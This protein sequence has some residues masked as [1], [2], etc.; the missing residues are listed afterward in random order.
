MVLLTL[1][2]WRRRVLQ[3]STS[4][5][6]LGGLRARLTG[7]VRNRFP[8]E[9]ALVSDTDL[10]AAADGVLWRPEEDGRLQPTDLVDW[11]RS[12]FGAAGITLSFADREPTVSVDDLESWEALLDHVDADALVTAFL[13]FQR[14]SSDPDADIRDLTHWGV[15]VRAGDRSLA[16]L[17]RQGVSDLHVHA[18]GV[19]FAHLA[20]FDLMDAQ[21]EAKTFSGLREKEQT[22]VALG[23]RCRSDLWN[24]LGVR[25]RPSE[26]APLS[27]LEEQWWRWD[28]RRLL[29]ERIL[30]AR[31]WQSA[32]KAPAVMRALD[33]YLFAK[34]CFFSEARQPGHTAPGLRVF[35]RYF[36]YVARTPGFVG[37]EV[38]AR[39]AMLPFG[40]ALAYLADCPN[41]ER[42]ELRAAPAGTAS[43]YGGL[44]KAF[45]Q[46]VQRFNSARGTNTDVRLAIHFKRS[47]R[48]S[49]RSGGLS[50]LSKTLR[51]LDR[52]S[53]ALRTA[54]AD[55]AFG[56]H[57]RYWLS[58]LDV[59][60]WERDT[61]AAYFAPYLR[62]ARGD[63][64]ALQD[65]EELDPED[66]R[67]PEFEAWLALRDRHDHR[68]SLAEARL[69]LTVHAG[70]DFADPLDGLCQ[71]ATAMQAFDMKPGDG[72]GHGLAIAVDLTR[73]D[74]ER[75]GFARIRQ[76]AHL[77]SLLWLCTLRTKTRSLDDFPAVADRVRR[78]VEQIAHTVYGLRCSI[79]D[80]LWLRQ[81]RIRPKSPNGLSRVR[82]QL[83]RLDVRTDVRSR[84]DILLPL[85]PVRS[86]LQD[87]VAWAQEEVLEQA[88]S[89][90]VV[91]E[92]NP[93][94]NWR[95]SASRELGLS[96]T[97]RI[98]QHIERGLLASINTDNPGTFLSRIENEYALLL[99]GCRATGVREG[100]ARDLLER[101]RM[102]GLRETWWPMRDGHAP[103]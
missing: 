90:R 37:G 79:D 53:A 74:S 47:R 76:G 6:V 19:R 35:E 96:P 22:Y 87:A 25:Y 40:D 2:C 13:T 14:S 98:L 9:T 12:L 85:P 18:G 70:E 86:V 103:Q 83:W 94:S 64:L 16:A 43:D 56:P 73:F 11:W 63:D 62:L 81:A 95:V 84:L 82:Q 26:D 52:E 23:C 78:E 65:L 21:T 31:A 32:R 1:I 28:R 33:A 61:P 27:D 92:M 46:L 54:L 4:A 36:R 91:V 50:P 66:P 29:G 41:L 93:G 80:L 5:A 15:T 72:I 42:V 51:T 30:L 17:V 44:A 38:S 8:I 100:V 39:L 7:E 97:V 89:R 34:S 67:A 60:G 101:A 59:A 49:D 69:G 45:G 3:Q 20:W 55:P 24:L 102:I 71:I 48:T 77:D 88:I 68:P 75:A 58:R 57:A 99:A 10:E